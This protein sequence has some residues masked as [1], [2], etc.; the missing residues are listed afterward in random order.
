MK[1]IPD[2]ANQP[3]IRLA[4]VM[5]AWKPARDGAPGQIGVCKHP[6]KG[7]LRH[8]PR[9][10]KPGHPTI[11]TT[12]ASQ[13]MLMIEA[14]HIACRDGVALADIHTALSAIPEYN[15]MLAVDFA[16]Q[17]TRPC[18]ELLE[19]ALPILEQVARDTLTLM[20]GNT[21]HKLFDQQQEKI[22][23]IKEALGKP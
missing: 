14:W 11:K 8:L 20:P 6:G 10:V 23:Q 3:V 19:Y 1:K 21:G 15:D 12:M 13:L 7:Q 22:Q 17:D 2:Q 16:V 5:I 18:R 4:E 9:W